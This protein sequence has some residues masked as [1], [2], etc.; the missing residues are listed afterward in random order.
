[1]IIPILTAEIKFDHDVVSARQRAR[2]IAGKL[3]FEPQD[4][5]RIATAVSEIARNAYRYAGGGTV[6]YSLDTMGGTSKTRSQSLRITV[7][8]RGQGI[9]DLQ[10]VLN[11]KYK[12]RTGMGMGILGTRRLMDTFAIESD[13]GGTRVS[14]AK[15]LPKTASHVDARLLEK[16]ASELASEKHIDPLSEVQHQNRELLQA[17]D[18][19]KRKQ[20]ELERLNGELEDTNRGVVALYAELDEKADH[21]RRADELK[22]KFL[23]NMSHEFRTPLNSIMALSRIL[24]DRT[25]GDLS[26]EQ[27]KQVGFIRKAAGDLTEL[28]NDLL[29]LAKVEAGKIVVQPVAFKLDNLFGALRGMMRPLLLSDTVSLIFEEVDHLPELYTDEG[30]LS[31]ILRNLI[32]NALKFTERGEI[33]VAAAYNRSSDVISLSVSDT[34][35]GVPPEHLETIF[36]EFAQVESA[37]QRRVKGTGLGLPLSRKLADLL[38]GELT[39]TSRPGHGSI[40]TATVPRRFGAAEVLEMPVVAPIIAAG[41][42]PL[43]IVDDREEDIL[44]YDKILR[45]TNYAVLIARTL[46]EARELLSRNPIQF[47]IL[48]ILLQGEEGWS[49]L[50]ELKNNSSAA[51]QV[52]VLTAIEDRGRAMALGADGY[53]GK[54]LSKDDLLQELE[55]L[56]KESRKPT[57]LVVDDE[58][59]SRY[60]VSQLLEDLGYTVLVAGHGEQAIRLATEVLPDLVILDLVMPGMSGLEV[61]TFLKSQQ[62]TAGVPLLLYTSKVLTKEEETKL[63]ALMD[64]VLMKDIATRSDALSALRSELSRIGSLTN[65]PRLIPV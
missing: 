51:T 39:V 45:D 6:S 52:L 50:K 44:V 9:D 13:A 43:L 7:E 58:E 22:S 46:K 64:G 19:L 5:T 2:V 18:E 53:L 38:G 41:K 63:H 61:G 57:A 16:I 8:D 36:Q 32:S 3:G 21:L 15:Q 17:L 25:D 10:S 14:F 30:K 33:R 12:S 4:Q 54:P 60:I 26:P 55:R 24:T 35:I 11:G 1:M 29:D 59:I 56:N 65:N 49:L 48:D 27:E 34:G 37:A 42:T 20:E 28:V 31:Q 47:V 62:S 23:N 40:F